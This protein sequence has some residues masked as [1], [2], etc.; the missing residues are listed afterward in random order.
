MSTQSD[1]ADRPSSNNAASDTTAILLDTTSPSRDGRRHPTLTNLDPRMPRF[2]T[3]AEC[4]KQR[5]IRFY[6]A[7]RA[8]DFECTCSTGA[9]ANLES[10]QADTSSASSAILPAASST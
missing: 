8:S 3:P 6:E 1:A 5:L 10:S 7:C 9:L 2:T 4:K